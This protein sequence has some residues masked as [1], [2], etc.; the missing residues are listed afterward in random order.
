MR[1][2]L[3][4]VIT[5]FCFSCGQK[6]NKGIVIDPAAKRLNDSAVNM[7]IKGDYVQAIALLDKAI[8]IDSNY[9]RAYYNKLNF[10]TSVKPIDKEKVIV[11]LRKLCWLRPDEP[12]YAMQLG[13]RYLKSTDTIPSTF[14]LQ[15][16]VAR[17]DRILDTTR[18]ADRAHDMLVINK[19]ASLI[20]LG[21]ERAG[22]KILATLYATT[23][24]DMIRELAGTEMNKSRKEVLAGIHFE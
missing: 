8:R 22:Q 9:F 24:D 11:T 18:A 2:I 19:A 15:E 12:E 20:L 7:G 3:L 1:T 13:M 10:Q 17:F 4:L 5:L 16:A 21:N 14:Y 6:S 23:K